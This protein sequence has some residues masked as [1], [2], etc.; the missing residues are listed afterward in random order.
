[1]FVDPPGQFQRI[2]CLDRTKDFGGAVRFIGLEC[3]NEV[4]TGAGEIGDFGVLAL[5]FL[6]IVLAEVA[7]AEGVSIADG[8][9]RKFFRYGEE[10]DAARV[11]ARAFGGLP[12]ARTDL[13]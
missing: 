3:A 11:A 12:D 5:E 8:G 10:R 6:D 9:G 7:Q 4:K 1:M 13:F 2:Y